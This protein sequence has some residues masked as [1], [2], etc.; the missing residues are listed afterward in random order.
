[1]ANVIGEPLDGYLAGQI[2]ARQFVNGSG[3]NSNRTDNEINLLTSNTSWVKLGSGISVNDARLDDIGLKSE[4]S[5]GMDLAK[6]NILFGG[7]S[8]LENQKTIQREGFLPRQSNSSY[9]YDKSFGFSPMAGIESVDVKTLNRGSLKK[10]TVKLKANDRSQFDIIE[11]LYLRLGYTVLLEWGNAFYTPDGSAKEIIHNTLMEEM[12]F[13]RESKGS[14]L[15]MLDPIESKRIKYAGNYDALFGKISNF[16][17]SFNPDGAYDIELTII[18]FGDVIESLK[19]NISP[20]A[21]M[22][23]FLN[24]A[25]PPTEEVESEEANIIEDNK[26]ANLISSMLYV[27]KY[28]NRGLNDSPFYKVTIQPNSGDVFHV[29]NFCEN[30]ETN[31]T[32]SATSYSYLFTITYIQKITV[33]KYQDFVDK[34]GH[35]GKLT[36]TTPNIEYQVLSPETY[37]DFTVITK[38]T[39]EIPQTFTPEQVKDGGVSQFQKELRE[40]YLALNK[41]HSQIPLWSSF[42]IKRKTTSSSTVTIDNPIESAPARSVFKLHT[43]TPNHYIRFGYLLEYI[44]DSILPRIKIDDNDHDKNPPVFDIDYDEW[45]SFMYSLPNQISLDPRVCIV[46]NSNFTSTG[47]TGNKAFPELMLYKPTSNENV[48]YPLNIYLNFEFVLESLKSDDRGN[49][50]VFDFI[51]NICTGLNKALGGINNLEPVIDENSN[52]LKIIDTT[53][54]PGYSNQPSI[55]PYILQIYGYDKTGTQ[56]Q[57]N[58]IR[59]FDLKTAITPEYATMITVGA[60]AGGYVKGTEATAFSKWNDGLIDRYKE[61]FT[62]GD[63]S[64]AKEQTTTTDEA[65]VNYVTKILSSNMLI[66]RYGFSSSKPTTFTLVDDIIESN[67]SIGTEYYKYLLSKNKLTSGGTIGFIPFKL[68]FKMDGISGIRIYNKLQVN[69]EF[70]PKAYGKY[71]NLIVTGISHN[72]SNNDWETSIETTVIPNSSPTNDLKI[73]LSKIIEE[74][75]TNVFN[76]PVTPSTPTTITSGTGLEPVKILISKGESFGG[77]YNIYNFGRN[78]AKGIRT[79]SVGKKKYNTKA[80]NL[81]TLTISQMLRYKG[82]GVNGTYIFAAG[83]FQ[84]IPKTLRSIATSLGVL[85]QPFNQTTQE[86]L[87]TYLLLKTRRAAGAYLSGR[88][89]G[90]INELAKA[91]EDIGQEWASMPVIW[92]KSGATVGSVVT[93]GGKTSYYGGVGINR[94]TSKFT[95][96]DMVQALITSRI[97]YSGIRPSFIPSYYKN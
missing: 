13:N 63:S 10:A 43:K 39:T 96:A 46:Q 90:S 9:T 76:D 68:S 38:L 72:L 73:D 82:S 95:V 31:G 49:A 80:V 89:G 36:P 51:S 47:G 71:T 60:T 32:I 12:F 50:N 45:N 55:N 94:G 1:M 5:A 18:S 34:G 97:Q 88:N 25:D 64:T 22:I 48:A 69:T 24:N 65:E 15:D 3:A 93:G 85:N 6:D 26:D 30:E 77:D 41:T 14:Y 53:P 79:S 23:S 4:Y 57:S 8:K 7:T 84:I 78:G 70:L 35:T 61:D 92:S 59:N 54:I 19:N 87:G 29:G 58:F 21:E 56:Y 62:P 75:I 67:I 44:T 91:V 74:T 40:K 11:L 37:G 52:T 42:K 16:T 2:E 66:K 81:S 33:Y 27:W 28:I 86:K 17:W 83:R 20:S